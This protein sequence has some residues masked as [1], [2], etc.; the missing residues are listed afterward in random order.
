M[1]KYMGKKKK[2]HW[3]KGK[4][5]QKQIKTKKTSIYVTFDILIYAYICF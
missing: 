2:R 3:C 1:E 4:L 5:I